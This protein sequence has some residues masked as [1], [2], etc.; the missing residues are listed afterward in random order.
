MG[1]L[2][3][4]VRRGIRTFVQAFAGTLLTL[5]LAQGIPTLVN[6]CK[7]PDLSLLLTLVAAAALAGVIALL[8]WLQ[9]WA[10][11]SPTVP[12]PAMLKAPASPGA[13]PTPRPDTL[14][15]RH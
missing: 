15:E 11:D 13:D 12:L 6:S 1:R 4:S 8:S 7:V 10:E 5:L 3:D 14:L 2:P 9:N